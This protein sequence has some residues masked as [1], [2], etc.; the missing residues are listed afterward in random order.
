M[1]RQRARDQAARSA[2]AAPADRDGGVSRSPASGRRNGSDAPARAPTI[3]DVARRAGV[4]KSLVSRV[5]R[6]GPAST[7]RSRAVLEAA[8]ALGYHPNAVARSLVQGKTFNIGVLISNIHNAFFA[9]V[10]DGIMAAAGAHGYHVLI[11]TGNRDPDAEAAAL[12]RLIQ[13]RV[14]GIILAGTAIPDDA[15]RRASR[16]VPATIIGTSSQIVGVDA[17]TTN[18]RAGAEMAVEHL[19][20]LGHRR[21]A[22]IDGGPTSRAVD[23]RVGYL[24]AMQRLGLG[25]STHVAIGDVTEDGGYRAARHLLASTPRPSAIFACNDLAALGALNALDEA[26]LGVPRDVSLVGYDNT[27]L[28]ALRHISLTTIDQPRL[29]IGEQALLLLLRRIERAGGRAKRQLLQPTLVVRA[30]TA[31]PLAST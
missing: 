25:D 1:A 16:S 27:R 24:A 8:E 6:G 30:T 7:A 14:D 22:F 9:E 15:V 12:E 18:D 28:A 23:R 29:E 31:P 3:I 5:L 19:A 2:S 21:I 26:G 10:L 13:L 4:S 17:V 11:A 20:G